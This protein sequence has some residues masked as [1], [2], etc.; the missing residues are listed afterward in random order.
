MAAAVATVVL[1]ISSVFVGVAV[2]VIGSVLGKPNKVIAPSSRQQSIQPPVEQ[3]DETTEQQQDKSAQIGVVTSSENSSFRRYRVHE[4]ERVVASLKANGPILVVGGEGMG[5]SVLANA[6]TEALTDEGYAVIEVKVATP[7]SMLKY[8]ADELGVPTMVDPLDPKPKALTLDQIKKNIEAQFK[9]MSKSKESAFLLID[10]AHKC[11]V[12]FR[13]WLKVLKRQGVP[14]FLTATNPPRSDIFI[15]LPRIELTPLPDHCIRE[16][17]EQAA[18]KIGL[19]LQ[20]NVLANL[21]QRAGGNPMLAQK[22]VSEEHLG[23]DN[24][25][26]DHTNYCDISPLLVLVGVVFMASKFLARGF[27]DPTLYVLSSMAGTVVIG[28]SKVF[29]GLPKESKRIK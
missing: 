7:R 17:M 12:K 4:L 28:L 18:M 9:E 24:E 23:I 19:S 8:M 11:E 14:M 2:F 27:N 22:A 21:Q 26:G 1:P 3:P 16:I 20:P 5:K 13:D 15:N 10:D 25:A 6:A 29:Y